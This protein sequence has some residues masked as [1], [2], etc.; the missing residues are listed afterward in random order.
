[1]PQEPD[2]K[3]E[4]LLKA[5][6]KKRRDDAGAPLEMHLA[7]R[8][9]L[10]GEVARLRPKPDSRPV[11]WFQLMLQFW[12]RIGFAVSIVIA[13]GVIVWMLNPGDKRSAEFAQAARK[14][15]PKSSSDD[16]DVAKDVALKREAAEKVSGSQRDGKS[17]SGPEKAVRESR[18]V[19]LNDEISLA[20][21]DFSKRA[22]VQRKLKQAAGGRSDPQTTP[23]EEAANGR[24]LSLS[25]PPA[26]APAPAPERKNLPPT[27]APALA[28]QPMEFGRSPV[29]GV[30]P[31]AGGLGGGTAQDRRG[32]NLGVE[33]NI[34]LQDSGTLSFSS[35]ASTNAVG[36]FSING[37]LS[38]DGAYGYSFQDGFLSSNT[39]FGNM[40]NY[41]SVFQPSIGAGISTNVSLLADNRANTPRPFFKQ[42]QKGAWNESS[43]S[44]LN[45][46]VSELRAADP[47]DIT[48][49]KSDQRTRQQ[50]ETAKVPAQQFGVDKD[51][52]SLA[53]RGQSAEGTATTTWSFV[54]EQLQIAQAGKEMAVTEARPA[55][56]RSSEVLRQ[57]RATARRDAT[58][59]LSSSVLSSFQMDLNGDRVRLTD[60]DGSVY[61]GQLAARSEAWERKAAEVRAEEQETVRGLEDVE[62]KQRA[63]ESRS[64]AVGYDAEAQPAS[65]RVTGTNRSLNQLVVLDAVLSAASGNRSEAAARGVATRFRTVDGLS[66][67]APAVPATPPAVTT[68]ATPSSV[69]T[70]KL[71]LART[72]SKQ[73]TASPSIRIQGKAW[74][75]ATNEIN[76]NAVR[77]AP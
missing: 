5:Y 30:T 20:E 71:P 55:P 75:G 6:A 48:L 73:S 40:A 34:A 27:D 11:S 18:A 38:G 10:Q 33:N 24:T 45:K 9:L 54:S 74:I 13:L 26:S 43:K 8:R 19:R 14:P 46:K 44:E 66:A 15:A 53:R 59:G 22:D 21:S 67:T 63:S 72:A 76:I 16:Y 29:G 68:P 31:G 50:Q 7:T 25:I 62:K 36:L 70:Q 39:L 3:I 51:L 37:R 35:V 65:F 56:E 52:D 69:S 4:E 47:G 77:I 2:K 1:M 61:E 58:G 23:R 49:A 17:A 41:Y 12:P 28:N 64:G 32:G 60:A 57:Y 42:E